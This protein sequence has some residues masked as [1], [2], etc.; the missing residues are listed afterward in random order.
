VLV[1]R[2]VVED[3]VVDPWRNPSCDPDPI[4]GVLDRRVRD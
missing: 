1:L 2:D 3:D 4:R